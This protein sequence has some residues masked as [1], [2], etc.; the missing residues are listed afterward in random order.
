LSY[1]RNALVEYTTRAFAQM[2]FARGS[3][4][5]FVPSPHETTGTAANVVKCHWI[6]FLLPAHAPVSGKMRQRDSFLK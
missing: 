5:G 4:S 1:S 2:E 3:G 6:V